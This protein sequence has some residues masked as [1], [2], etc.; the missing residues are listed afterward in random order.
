[1]QKP[2]LKM[3]ALFLLSGATAFAGSFSSDFSNPSQS[4]IQFNGSGT[5]TDGSAWAALIS[6]GALVLTTNQNSLGG[7]ANI[8]DL[9]SGQAIESFTVRFQLQLGPGTGNAADGASLTFGP[10]VTPSS[11]FTEEGP[12]ATGTAN[13]DITI[14]FDTYDN[15]TVN[16]YVDGAPS[17]D[18]KLFGYEIGHT[19]YTKAD[20]VDSKLEDVYVQVKRNGILN[21]SYKGQIIYTNLYLPGWGSTNGQFNFS[22]RTGGENEV[23]LIDNL[24]ITTVVAPATPVAPTIAANPQNANVNEGNPVTFT[25][26]FDGNAPFTFQWYENGQPIQDATNTTFTLAPAHYADNNGKFKCTVSNASGSAT[27]A[28]ATLTVVADTTPPTVVSAAGSLDFT[29]ATITFS[30]PMQQ[31]SVE[32]IGNYTIP[33]LTISAAGQSPTDQKT[34]VLTTSQ[35][36]VGASYTI[37]IKDVK[38]QATTPNT[39][40]PNP[41]SV[42]FR[43]FAWQLGRAVHE[44]Y[45]GFDDNAGANVNNLLNDPRVPAAPDRIDLMTA[46][47][48]PAGGAGRDAVADP[49]RDYFDAIE[50]FFIPPVTTNYVFFIAFADR[51]WLYLSTDE[52]SANKKQILAMSGWTNPRDWNLGQGGTDMTQARTDSSTT[53]AANW[54]GGNIISLQA[55]KKY[56]MLSVHHS[57]SWSGGDDFSVTYKYEGDNDPANGTA[58]RTTGNVIGTYLN[59]AGAVVNITVQPTNTT[60]VNAKKV[61]FA[62]AA[63][64]S[65]LYGNTVSFQWQKAPPGSSTFTDIAG[66]TQTTYTTPQLTLADSGSQF[67]V[68]CY[69][70]GLSELSSVAT[71]T[72]VPDTFPPVVTSV[73][74]IS[75]FG[76]GVQVAVSFDEALN[77]ST[78][79]PANF[80]LSAGTVTA[81]S[82]ATNSYSTINAAILDVTGL[83]LGGSYTVTVKGVADALGNAIP[84]PGITT[85]FTVSSTLGWANSGT[86]IRPGQVI[87]VGSDGFDILNG[88]RQ[89]WGTYDEITMAYVKKTNDFDVRVNVVYAEPGS[90]WSRV[91]LQARYDMNVGEPADDR[92]VATG[93]ASA[94][95]QTHV[96]PAQTLAS[97]GAWDPNDPIQPVNPTPNNGHEQNCRIAAGSTTQGW[98]SPGTA[99]TYPNAWLRLAR[100]GA[101]LHGYRS[102]DGITWVDQGTISLTDQFAAMYV[103]PFLAVETGNIWPSSF[104]LWNTYDPTYDRLFVAQFR[105][106]GDTPTIVPQA[107]ITIKRLGNQVVLSWGVAGTLQQSTVLGGAASWGAVPGA[108]NTPTG[109]SYTNTPAGTATFFRLLQQ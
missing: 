3:L 104:D 101:T 11:M 72:V 64:G 98:G 78:L 44:K 25:V 8:D 96:N 43:S 12:T 79:V 71:L 56:Y 94:Y 66:A 91:G 59:P 29:H 36:T 9:D 32:T 77:Q 55:G 95:A 49:T 13:P 68:N 106:F 33:G 21:M 97:S 50:G 23:T 73:G 83:T 60:G 67:R 86:Q 22:A 35:Q 28:E 31:S 107:P 76:G 38:D 109:G 89:E 52:T 63:T 75:T 87:P 4:G 99:P 48:Y 105:S 90:Q 54:P 85:S 14:E 102:T 26:G 15:G 42:T 65:S 80:T 47:E 40:A 46:Y 51:G 58:P 5:L 18:I 37:S 34:V 41:S 19:S 53:T 45:N 93:T 70:P 30:E 6:G 108:P 2:T 1:M 62:V 92:N 57:P 17:V 27:S 39:I 103:G 84:A 82:P 16:G 24:N 88:G 100:T 61:T 69:V 74:G 7:A 81:V 20:M 10:D